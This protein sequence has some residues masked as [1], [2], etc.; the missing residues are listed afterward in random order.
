M[1]EVSQNLGAGD[2]SGV[3]VTVVV[4]VGDR[5]PRKLEMVLYRQLEAPA[6]KKHKHYCIKTLFNLS[7]QLVAA[8]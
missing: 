7:M 2:S 5:G 4:V 6:R 3:V 1:W 8:L